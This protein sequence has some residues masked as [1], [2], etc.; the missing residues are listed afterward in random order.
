MRTEK[1]NGTSVIS[2]L[3]TFAEKQ[4]V[5][6]QLN[7]LLGNIKPDIEMLANIT[8]NG[9]PAEA[10]KR[11]D[12]ESIGF[13]RGKKFLGAYSVCGLPPVLIVTTVGLAL[14]KLNQDGR[15]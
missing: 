14:Q 2:E 6:N 4:M 11:G 8:K 9:K 13:F 12:I 15:L 3:E 10:Q 5:F 1:E 7:V